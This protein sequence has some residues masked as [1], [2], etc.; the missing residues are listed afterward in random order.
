MMQM[1]A[2][3]NPLDQLKDI[4][5]PDAIGLWPPAIGWY[6]V[7]I[8]L[9]AVLVLAGV[10][11]WRRWQQNAYRR[12]ALRECDEIEREITA[13]SDCRAAAIRIATLLKRTA[14]SV[15]PRG[16]VAP[17]SGDAWI[18]FLESN[19]SET[20]FSIASSQLLIE[21]SFRES[22]PDNQSDVAQLLIEAR[23]WIRKH[24]RPNLASGGEH[25]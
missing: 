13:G 16:E 19:A 10:M 23:Q 11:L 12:A 7:L 4:H 3:A 15:F 1:P 17:L 5:T 18:L 6:L 9:I 20:R 25:A 2:T 21:A 14:L 22:P 24:Q 8:F